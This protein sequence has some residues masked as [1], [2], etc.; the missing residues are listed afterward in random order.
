MLRLS[1]VGDTGDVN[2][3]DLAQSA[4][5]TNSPGSIWLVDKVVIMRCR[6][7]VQQPGCRALPSPAARRQLDLPSTSQRP[8]VT[9]GRPPRT[10]RLVMAPIVR[11][12]R[13]MICRATRGGSASPLKR[14]AILQ[15]WLCKTQQR[16]RR[17]RRVRARSSPL[18]TQ[19]GR[20]PR[21]GT[22][23]KVTRPQ[24]FVFDHARSCHTM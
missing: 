14:P 17:R 19:T 22:R 3:R 8:S 13:K 6:Q 7:D 18:P 4:R 24:K 2:G 5:T 20:R 21:R 9:L 16:G 11:R 1:L 23:E 10:V 15:P 12:M